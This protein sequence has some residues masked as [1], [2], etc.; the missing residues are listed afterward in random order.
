MGTTRLT[1]N[2]QSSPLL[3]RSGQLAS[4]ED[5]LA[6]VRRTGNGR[7]ITVAGEA[8]VGKTMLLSRF[9]SLHAADARTL[10]GT[11][12]ALHTPRPLGPFQDIAR[13]THGQLEASLAGS[14]KPYQVADALMDEL[15]ADSPTI[16]VLDDLHSADEATLDVLRLVGR[17]AASVPALIVAAHRS[18][19][20][21]RLHPLRVVLGELRVSVAN[22]LH[23]QPL[24]LAGVA[25]LAEPHGV[26]AHDLHL[27]TGG[28]PFFVTEVLAGGGAGIPNSVSDAVLA[29]T[30][31]LGEAARSV[32]DA[33][34]IAPPRV[35][36]WLLKGLV[37]EAAQS[38]D[39][40]LASGMLT[41][42]DGN[43]E[44]R[45][46]LAR[47]AV[48]EALAPARRLALHRK[49][50]EALAEPPTGTPDLARLAHHAEGSEDPQAVLRYAPAAAEHAAALGARREAAAQYA[51]ALRFTGGLP[52][53]QR[54]DLLERH[55]FECYLTDL[56]ADSIDSLREAIAIRRE[57]GNVRREAADLSLLSRR[58]WCTG[59]EAEAEQ[60]GR[61]AV[62]SLEQLPEGP[63]LALACSNLSQLALNAEDARAT[64][65]WGERALALAERLGNTEVVVHSLNNMG[66]MELLRGERGGLAKL[67]QSIELADAAGLD[68]HVGRG[69]IH[70]GWAITR[71]R[72]YDL[73]HLLATG[74]ATCRERG[75]D[76]WRA[77]VE[78]YQARLNLDQ[79]RWEDAREAAMEVL[80]HPR[81][82]VL[83]RLLSLAVLGTLRA[84]RGE[85]EPW[86]P[87]DEAR[88]LARGTTDLQHLAPVA[89]ASAEA[90]W[91]EGRNG[92]VADA[93]DPAIDLARR[94]D[95]A[96]IIGE[97]A[98][99][100][101]RAGISEP[102][103]AGLPTP[104][105]AQL[106]GDWAGAAALWSDLGCPYEAALALADADDDDA[107]R[108]AHG[109]LRRLG[110][111]PA[112][113][114]VARRLRERGVRGVSRGPRAVTLEDPN[115]L[116]PREAEVLELVARGM[117]NAEIGRRLFLSP[118][119]IDHHVAAVLRKLG[120]R[121]RAE[122]SVAAQ[123][124]GQNA[125]K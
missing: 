40:C 9:C 107:L 47:R 46:E 15:S 32:V 70:L 10:W 49:A 105:A 4:L 62:E 80:S 54:A 125:Q 110:A 28:N 39:E 114:M 64:F 2:G 25:E 100:R 83:L 21:S 66:A 52:P 87:L 97:L 102:V 96:W 44:F 90:L 63:E 99:W 11:C 60:A 16:L 98:T 51:R 106:S 117:R 41:M 65:T 103:P 19:Q 17:R 101:R 22:R 5:A 109:E 93:T 8:G 35:E 108:R 120:V 75:L 26:K 121:S 95:A 94:S 37:G 3:E 48:E 57:L 86:P 81:E 71:T 59:R 74:I 92:A 31:G 79:G 113:E 58:L 115:R 45:H 50:L 27:T 91:L 53:E 7:L 14:A 30:V 112:A 67:E 77:Y 72:A 29:R 61:E 12:D 85:P 89:V 18:D 20:L 55:S 84:R 68:E 56:A 34:A 1:T 33:V 23:V 38:L 76:L 119:T 82:T 43:L 6:A 122:A 123:R 69:Y 78:T 42:H 124:R 104:Y 111:V 73:A 88:T 118:R 24:S 13:S 36:A 116:T